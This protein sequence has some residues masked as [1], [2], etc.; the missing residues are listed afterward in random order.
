MKTVTLDQR[1]F[2]SPQTRAKK[3]AAGKSGKSPSALTRKRSTK[4][5]GLQARIDLLVERALALE[6]AGELKPNSQDVIRHISS[7]LMMNG[8]ARAVRIG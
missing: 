2:N 5:R 6:A 3:A 1:G 4:D 7:R 8:R